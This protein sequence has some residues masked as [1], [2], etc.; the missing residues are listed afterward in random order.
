MLAFEC[1]IRCSVA[2]IRNIVWRKLDRPFNLS[3]HRHCLIRGEDATHPPLRAIDA[4]IMQLVTSSEFAAASGAAAAFGGGGGAA[5][6]AT[7]AVVVVV[8]GGAV[9]GGGGGVM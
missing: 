3:A 5:A 4:A 7:T 6:A 2:K 8:G 1:L 9:V